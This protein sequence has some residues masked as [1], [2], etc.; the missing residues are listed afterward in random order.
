[1]TIACALLLVVIDNAR[2]PRAKTGNF[3][4]IYTQKVPPLPECNVDELKLVGTPLTPDYFS[5]SNQIQKEPEPKL[6][7][8]STILDINDTNNYM[9]YVRSEMRKTLEK[10][11]T[12]I[13]TERARKKK[14][15]NGDKS[16]KEQ[17]LS[18][19]NKNIDKGVE[20]VL[21]M[22]NIFKVDKPKDKEHATSASQVDVTDLIGDTKQE[23]DSIKETLLKITESTDSSQNNIFNDVIKLLNSLHKE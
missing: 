2:D 19:S 12:I 17:E 8:S 22:K 5:K 9:K 16:V 14:I 4:L 18:K 21:E 6:D 11:L 3:E 10:L 7:P 15:K 13:K 23:I 1:M 20:C